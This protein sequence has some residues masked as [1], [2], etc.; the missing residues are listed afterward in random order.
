MVQG[1]PFIAAVLNQLNAVQREAACYLDGPLL[2]LAGAGSGKTRVITQKIAWL[3]DACGYAPQHIAAITFTNKAA[4]EMQGRMRQLLPGTSTKGLTV[5]TFHAL[6]LQI[7]RQ[8]AVNIGYKPQFSVLDMADTQQIMIGLLK[9]ADKQVVRRVSLHISQWKNALLGPAEA[10]AKAESDLDMQDALVYQ[11]YQ[12]TLKA[13]QAMDFDDLIR[14]PAEL[15]GNRSDLL[16]RWRK[17]LN[18]LLIDE[19]QDTN[20]CQYAIVK[21]LCGVSGAFTAVGDDDQAIYGWR[22]ADAGNMRQLH[23]DFPQ[24][25]VIQLTQNY[26]STLRILQAANSVIANNERMYDKQL[27]SEHGLGDPL[28]ILATRDD[29]DEAQKVVMRLM[30]H[31]FE[32][33]T[34]FSDYAILYRSNHQARI[35]EQSLRNEKIPYE[36]SGGVSYFDR[37]EIKDIL[38]YLRLLTNDDDDPAFI[39]AVTSPRRGI[40]ATTL[41][42]L[43][44]YA[45]SRQISLF[46][47]A[48]ETGL[49][50]QLPTP[51]LQ[52]LMTFCEYINR[53]HD[54][55]VR[56]PV[57]EL[58][59][60][61]LRDIGYEAWLF[62]NEEGR[63]AQTRWNNVQEFVA[64]MARKGEADQKNLFELTQTI[65][66]ITLLDKRDQ[67]DMDA[68]RL[69][70]IHAAKGLEF[71]HVFLIGVEEGLLPHRESVDN[72]TL[73][74]ERRLMYVAITR[75]QRSLTLSYC[76]KRKRGGDWEGCEPS[77]FISEIADETIRRPDAQVDPAQARERG[78]AR[79]AQLKAMLTETPQF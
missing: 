34:Q 6:G 65:A 13:Y 1:S 74:E 52:A 68:V 49:Q 25:K 19:Y 78:S 79:L 53:L 58:L 5:C 36:M 69:S 8:E 42:R 62:D 59:A 50:S 76:Q 55:V 73:E 66:L 15:F 12:N 3:I 64:W 18:Y 54:R 31:K 32:C 75:A 48:F 23:V 17:K 11:A 51:Q 22:G 77:R 40:G 71:G 16:E 43:G 2:V 33:R 4:S 14:L 10:R 46:A 38:A 61:L 37:A 56:T 20:A 67:E 27:W 26:R 39:R 44:E 21:Q 41:E 35:L 57:G 70:T 63:A 45:G 72:G 47:A 9:T 30:A 29:A 7:L 60:D 24:L 28:Q